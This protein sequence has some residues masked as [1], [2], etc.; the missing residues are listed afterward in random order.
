MF[1]DKK[2]FIYV[3]QA[4]KGKT[5]AL[6]RV[7]RV[8]KNNPERIGA[9]VLAN[10]PEILKDRDSVVEHWLKTKGFVPESHEAGKHFHVEAV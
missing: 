10:F 5:P 9:V 2:T 7:Y 3:V 6:A 8:K 4:P 1:K